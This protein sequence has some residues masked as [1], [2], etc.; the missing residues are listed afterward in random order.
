VV[1]RLK[2]VRLSYLAAIASILLVWQTGAYV[3]QKPFLLPGV[4]ATFQHVPEVLK[5][6]EFLNGI[7]ASFM[8][9]GTG[10]PLAC[11]AGAVLGLTAGLSRPFAIY[12]RGLISILQSVPPITWL[13]FLLIMLG[14][15]HLPIIVVVTIAS[16]FPMALTVMNGAE[17]VSKTHV[18]LARVMGAS[19]WQ[20]LVKVYAPET[21]PSVITGAQVAFGNAWRSLI[22]AEMV[23]GTSAGLGFT[24]K[25]AGEI[26][27]MKGMLLGIVVVGATAAFLDHFVLEQLKRRLLS[28]RPTAGGE[29]P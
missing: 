21:L 26:A 4:L 18:E 23:S 29:T 28:W 10:Y 3:L 14:F 17:G 8:R 20:L 5:R 11:L 7:Q 15:G 22:A 6:P 27:N 16:F 2:S 13:P 9:L 19:R 12:L 24:I 25:F 1:H